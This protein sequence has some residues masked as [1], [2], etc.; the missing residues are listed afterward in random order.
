MKDDNHYANEILDRVSHLRADKI[1]VNSQLQADHTIIIP[2]WRSLS[3]ISNGAEPRGVLLPA[4][5]ARG[6]L[7]TACAT[8]LLGLRNEVAHFAVDISHLEEHDARINVSNSAFTDLRSVGAVMDR[9]EASILAYAKGITHWHAQHMYC[10]VCGNPTEIQDAGHLRK[11]LDPD[12]GAVHFPRTDPAVIMLVAKDDRALLGRKAEWMED[13]Y[14][15]LAGFVEPGESLE[16]AVARE[17]FE[18]AGVKITNIR[19]HSSQPWPFPASLMLGFFAEAVTEDLVRSEEELED[20]QWF[21]RKELADGG[22]GIAKRPR[23]DSIAR[24]LIDDWIRM[25]D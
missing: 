16:Q 25:A 19:Y 20:L 14:S 10:G 21:T 9:S 1:W 3:L 12:C 15:T 5:Q 24:R 18:E 8:V 23:S 17:V 4:S 13:M 11:C 2:V 22:A 6:L 7:E